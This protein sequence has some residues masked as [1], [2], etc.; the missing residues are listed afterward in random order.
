MKPSVYGKKQGSVFLLLE[1]NYDLYY[2]TLAHDSVPNRARRL[3]Y[4]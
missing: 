4:R 3:T 2:I 1:L